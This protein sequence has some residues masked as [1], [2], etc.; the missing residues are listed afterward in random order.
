M[1]ISARLTALTWRLLVGICAR[2]HLFAQV[3]ADSQTFF[4]IKSGTCSLLSLLCAT[5]ETGLRH[6][7]V[8]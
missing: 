4:G 7:V 5:M 3:E 8:I 1:S 6:M 2:V